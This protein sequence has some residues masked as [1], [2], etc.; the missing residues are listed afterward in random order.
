MIDSKKTHEKQK[1]LTDLLKMYP[2]V[3]KIR[4]ESV[5]ESAGKIR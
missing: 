1:I 5:S 4:V 2:N 3:S